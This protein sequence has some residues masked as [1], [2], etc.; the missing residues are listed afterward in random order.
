MSNEIKI[1]EFSGD[2]EYD[3]IQV[4]LTELNQKISSYNFSIST[5][6]KIL[7]IAVECLE[8]IYK[9]T[10]TKLYKNGKKLTSAFSVTKLEDAIYISSGNLIFSEQAEKVRSRIDLINNASRDELLTAY[11]DIINNGHIS[12]KGG[13]GLGLIDMALKSGNCLICSFNEAENNEL[14]FEF[15]VKVDI[16]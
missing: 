11:E 2:L 16:K 5:R 9:Y 10:E 8:N 4:L 13:A 7:N 6:K 12:S 15:K 14:Y 1:V 3:M